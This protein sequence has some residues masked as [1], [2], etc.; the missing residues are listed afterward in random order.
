M[1]WIEDVAVSSSHFLMGF[2]DYTPFLFVA[3]G[4]LG[5]LLHRFLTKKGVS[6]LRSA[7]PLWAFIVLGGLWWIQNLIEKVG[8]LR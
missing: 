1:K 4:S 5:L 3:G 7:E 6:Q 8:L 2:D